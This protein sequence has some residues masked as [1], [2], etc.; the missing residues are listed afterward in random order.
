MRWVAGRLL[1]VRDGSPEGAA[2]RRLGYQSVSTLTAWPISRPFFPSHFTES[3]GWTR[4]PIE[5]PRTPPR[6]RVSLVGEEPTTAAV[7]RH[8][9]APA[10]DTPAEPIA[11]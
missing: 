3:G 9:D 10:G 7:R 4:D 5:S 11:R 8:L 2:H 1:L 6:W